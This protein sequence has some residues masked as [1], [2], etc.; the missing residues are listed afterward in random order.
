MDYNIEPLSKGKWDGYELKFAYET[1]SYYDIDLK[2]TENGFI[3]NLEKKAFDSTI[4]KTF[5]DKLFAPYLEN[6]EV[7]GVISGEKIL[8][9]IEISKE[10]WNNR[11]RINTLLVDENLRGKGIGKKL[12]ELAINRAKEMNCRS[13]VLETQSC[14][15]KALA[16]YFS[17]GFTLVGFDTNC[18]SNDDISKKEVRFELAINL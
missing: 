14:N 11:L 1:N 8:A 10:E 17:Q 18:Y 13:V 7:Y 4:K 15:E 9:S 6:P 3:F 12:M 2:S 5:S 16:F